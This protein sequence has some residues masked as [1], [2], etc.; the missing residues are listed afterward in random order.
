MWC[1]G[2]PGRGDGRQGEVRA[3]GH[4]VAVG[5]RRPGEG[6]P[7]VGRHQVGGP[8]DAC[9]L[10][11]AGDVV[12]VDMRLHHMGDAHSSAGGGG[13]HPVDVTG[14]VHRHPRVFPTGEVAAVAQ[15]LDLDHLDEEHPILPSRGKVPR[16]VF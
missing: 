15:A 6:D 3:H 2:V 11:A 16:G 13:Q 8:G 7:R 12:V 4:G 1:G 10:Q 9:E 14:R 5:D